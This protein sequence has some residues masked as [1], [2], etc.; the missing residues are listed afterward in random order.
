MG[1]DATVWWI[2]W[3]GG[4]VLES[5]DEHDWVQDGERCYCQ[6]CSAERGDR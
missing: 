6:A 2:E 1:E 4:G 5:T 3:V